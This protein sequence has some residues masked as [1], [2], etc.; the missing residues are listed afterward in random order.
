MYDAI[1]K[2]ATNDPEFSFTTRNT[3]YPLTNAV[4][5][6]KIRGNALSMVF[7]TGV[8][9]AMVCSSVIGHVVQE[10]V[11]GYKHMQLISGLNLSAY[12][13]A[14]F[15]VDFIKM[16]CV[17]APAVIAFYIFDMKYYSSWLTFLCYPL[18]WIPF[19]YVMSFAFATL[20]SAQTF[21]MA[22]NFAFIVFISVIVNAMRWIK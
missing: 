4:V 15:F 10:R 3:P 18:A 1:L 20:S 19:S 8:A 21:A 5:K 7:I 6:R 22:F 2:V 16:E 13:I 12:W 11:E 14:N 17:I 9:F